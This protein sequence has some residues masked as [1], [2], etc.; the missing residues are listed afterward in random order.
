MK[1]KSQ[2][3]TKF[4]KILYNERGKEVGVLLSHAKYEKLMDLIDDYH[5]C[6]TVIKL[7][8]Q[9]RPQKIY[10]SEEIREMLSLLYSQRSEISSIN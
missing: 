10:T 9:P 1:A 7:R 5:D 3:E 4:A 8:K 6:K 2:K